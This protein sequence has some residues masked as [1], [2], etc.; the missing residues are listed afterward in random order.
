[1][2]ELADL[3]AKRPDLMR[4][5]AEAHDKSARRGNISLLTV[6][7]AAAGSGC[8]FSAIA[9][10]LMTL[11][12]N[13]APIEQCMELLGSK[14]PVATAA[15]MLCKGQKVPGWG[16]SF[17]KGKPD[18]DWD[19]VAKCL[20]GQWVAVSIRAI[21]KRLQESGKIIYPNPGCY[22][23]AAAIVM[24]IHPKVAAYLFVASRLLAWTDVAA[25][26]LCGKKEVEH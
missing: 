25:M 10:G 26:Q 18:P 5:L 15:E 9:A 12:G 6:A 1:M 24:G 21:T 8:Y 16:N 20:E 22:T 14:D 7:N 17:V 4:A 13:H 11:G 19:G 23:A 2:S 3:M